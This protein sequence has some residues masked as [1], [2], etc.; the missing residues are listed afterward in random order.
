MIGLL[1]VFRV[2]CAVMSGRARAW[3]AGKEPLQTVIDVV[4]SVIGMS[5]NGHSQK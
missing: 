1:V 3:L 2:F 4:P 5:G